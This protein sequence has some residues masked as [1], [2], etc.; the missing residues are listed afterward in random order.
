MLRPPRC[1]RK[2]SSAARNAKR[3]NPSNAHAPA[4]MGEKGLRWNGP[5]V[6]A[7]MPMASDGLDTISM[8]R[9]R[10]G[11]PRSTVKRIGPGVTARKA[12]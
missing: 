9:K 10:V 8:W 3:L 1:S 11:T 12:M 4:F 2:T 6:T 5:T 7:S